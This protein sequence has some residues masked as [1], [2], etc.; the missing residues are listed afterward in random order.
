MSVL[1]EETIQ[2]SFTATLSIDLETDI[3]LEHIVIENKDLQ[4]HIHA[5]YG[6]CKTLLCFCG[7]FKP[8]TK[9]KGYCTCG[10][11]ATN[12]YRA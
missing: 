12:H 11:H 7:G 3:S 6:G 4:F 2:D 1:N 8:D 10:H 5:G 9:K